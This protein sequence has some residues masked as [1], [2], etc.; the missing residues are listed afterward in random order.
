MSGSP[1]AAAEAGRGGGGGS[2]ISPI[3]PLLTA[4]F[5]P[6]PSWPEAGVRAVMD[7]LHDAIVA[8]DVHGRIHYI[9]PAGERLLG[10]PADELTGQSAL[11][12][13][14][15]SMLSYLS[16][17][18]ESFVG[19][20]A[21]KLTGQPLGAIIR[22]HDGSEMPTQLVLSIF[23][24]PAAGRV[25]VGVFRPEADQRLERW[26]QLTTELIELLAGASVA[27]PP[28][29][30][31]L[32]TIGKNLGWDVTTLWTLTTPHGLKCRHVWTRSPDV[33]PAFVEEK[34][35]DP[36]NGWR[37]LPQWVYEHAEPIWIPDLLSDNRFVTDAVRRDGLTSAYAFPI[38]YRGTCVG[39]IKMLSKAKRDRDPG[40]VDLMDA[41]GDHLGELLYAYAQATEREQLVNELQESRRSQEFLLAATQVLSETVDYREM[42]SKLAQV[43]VPVL[44][45]LC[46]I[47]ILSEQH[48]IER[49]AAWHADPAKRALT[50]E[51]R[52]GYPPDP[53]GNHPSIE[54]MRTGQSRWDAVMTDEFLRSTT[55]D[56]RH[57]SILKQLEFTSY[58]TVPLRVH[59]RI[60]GTVTLV[61]AGSGRRFSEEDLILAEQL[62]AQV[63]SVVD[64]ARAYD[65]ERRIS[66][67]LQR[68]LLPDQLPWVEGWALAARYV[69]ATV[70]VEVGGD[71]YDAVPLSDGSV[72]L[73]VGDV[74]G[75]D[76]GAAKVMSRLRHVL[77]L[78]VWEDRR[79]GRSLERLNRFMLAGDM[80]RIATV[81]VGVLNPESG[82]IVI[83]SAGHPSAIAVGTDGVRELTIDPGPPLGVPASSFSERTFE[84]GDDCLL[85]FTDGLFERR[86][87]PMGERT[88]QLLA[89]ASSASDAAPSTLTDVLLSEMLSDGVGVD[90]VAI[91]AAR[92]R[93]VL[94]HDS[95]W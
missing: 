68:N 58:M 5:S 24:H 18:F 22:R 57:F 16:A 15:E 84:L 59:N 48:E 21:M 9:N 45:D 75:H 50:E 87:V 88:A 28:A 31:L 20:R 52:N 19:D 2:P 36:T 76:M 8:T 55:H 30:R 33:A 54:V 6:E 89:A 86:E 72:A 11:K 23:D 63:G 78:L 60:L 4:E 81:L 42:V 40:V 14:P 17:G 7:E 91:L 80:E 39:V 73:I 79:P 3:Q 90:D 38:R 70:G 94:P 27:N 35:K 92:R 95:A 53:D 67:E 61:S 1:E 43:S 12:L 64:R 34:T 29:E 41:V 13:V 46:I 71:W 74:A 10:W 83:A 32:S 65:Q 49:M 25:V 77:S 56:K 51:L 62:A 66:H 85:M 82:R 26:S 37:G 93:A 44:A 69:P 47:D